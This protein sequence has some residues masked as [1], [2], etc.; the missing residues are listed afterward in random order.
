[1]KEAAIGVK[2]RFMGDLRALIREESLEMALPPGSTLGDLMASLS[3]RYGD[4][5][6]CR[7]FS[8]PGKLHHYMLVFANGQN[9]QEAGGL[10]MRLDRGEVEVIMLPMFEGG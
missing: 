6:T 5:F 10:A 2:V 3:R 9:I 8:Q 7:V 1:M 4:P